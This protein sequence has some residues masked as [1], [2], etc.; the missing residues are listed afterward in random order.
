[1]RREV[2]PGAV[3]DRPRDRRLGIEVLHQR[4]E[5]DEA[6]VAPGGERRLLPVKGQAARAGPVFPL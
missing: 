4:V 2:G 6:G 3:E 5:L 1:M